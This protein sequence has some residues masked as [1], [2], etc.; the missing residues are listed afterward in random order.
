M[1]G[2]RGE[3]GGERVCAPS[4]PPAE[5]LDALGIESQLVDR[6]RRVGRQHV[7]DRR[8]R[9]ERLG[10]FLP[11]LLTCG[12]DH[13]EGIAPPAAHADRLGQGDRGAR[14]QRR[15][16]G[17]RER[18]LEMSLPRR[19]AQRRLRGSQQ[20]EDLGRGRVGGCLVEC[21]LEPARGLVGRRMRQGVLARC[22]QHGGS[23][24]RAVGRHDGEVAGDRLD[25]RSR[26]REQVGGCGM[27]GVP[28]HRVEARVDR[29]P[30]QGMHER[31]RILARQHLDPPQPG[32]DVPG[33]ADR[34]TRQCGR[35]RQR[36]SV[37]EDRHRHCQRPGRRSHPGDAPH[38]P[39]SERQHRRRS[40][41]APGLVTGR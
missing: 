11:D 26:V 3:H 15:I 20:R 9:C 32:R 1:R 39:V 19:V 21:A 27:G 40:K 8:E 29:P 31:D 12:G 6:P 14:A 35:C 28:S 7:T 38:D 17:M 25:R 22:D 36:G 37:A 30:H 33:L 13:G 34:K 41:D 4:R 5:R 24:R 16:H 18:G 2:E 23:G 10:I